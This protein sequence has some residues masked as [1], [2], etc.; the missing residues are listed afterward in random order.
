MKDKLIKKNKSLKLAIE[1]YNLFQSFIN[2]YKKTKSLDDYVEHL[3]STSGGLSEDTVDRYKSMIYRYE[4]GNAEPLLSNLYNRL[5][6]VDEYKNK[7]ANEI[8]L[9]LKESW[10]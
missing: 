10:K 6:A 8:K 1:H 5:L 3:K 2:T 4:H 9:L 7:L